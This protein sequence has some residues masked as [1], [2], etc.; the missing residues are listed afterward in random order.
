MSALQSGYF[1]GSKKFSSVQ[2]TFFSS[3][4]S[5]QCY[6]ANQFPLDAN[7]TRVRGRVRVHD[8][9]N[10]IYAKAMK[11]VALKEGEVNVCIPSVVGGRG[12]GRKRKIE[13]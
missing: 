4:F 10:R 7:L 2:D 6:G 13:R 12:K 11:H 5:R 3:S 9:C 8:I 1:F